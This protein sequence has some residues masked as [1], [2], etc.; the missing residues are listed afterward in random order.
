ML[1]LGSALTGFARAL[2]INP[3]LPRVRS[4]PAI[5][6][7]AQ[8]ALKPQPHT[9]PF[10]MPSEKYHNFDLVNRVKVK[11]G[12]V[13]ISKW[14]SRVSGLTLVHVD[15]QA[16]IV[17]GYFVVRSEIFNDSGCPHTLEHLVFMGSEKYP[18]KGVLDNLATRG[19]AEGT[20]AWTATDHTAYTISTAGGQGF[21]QLLPVYVDHIL[22]PTLTKSSFITEV[23]HVDVEGRDSGVVYSEMQGRENTPGDIAALRLQ[24]L[25]NPTGSAYRSETGGL[26]EALRV[27]T[28]NDIRKYH[29]EY[30]VPHNLSLIVSGKLNTQD[31]L[32][33]LQ[34]QVEPS[35]VK[36]GQTYGA[37][38]PPGFKRPFIETPSA[39]RPP[40]EK[41][42]TATTEF[43]EKDE[44]MGEVWMSFRGSKC[45]DFLTNGALDIMGNYLT[46]TAT[47]PLNKDLVEIPEPLCAGIWLSETDRATTN[48]IDFVASSVPTEELE[49]FDE[50]VLESLRKVVSEGIDM[51]K[52]QVIIERERRKLFAGLESKGGEIFADTLIADFLYFRENGEDLAEEVN[53]IEQFDELSRW[54]EQQWKDLLKTY[55]IDAHRVV[56]RAKPSSALQE[57]LESDESARV[58]AQVKKLGPEGLKKLGEELGAAKEE[59]DKPVPQEMLTEFP[60]PSVDSIGWI[61]VT[62]AQN[63]SRGRVVPAPGGDALATHIA[64]DGV[65]L[66]VFV[67]F[68]NIQSKFFSID[69]YISTA[70]L[71]DEL[72][73]LLSVY[74]ASFFSLPVTRSDG[75]KLSHEQ[76][77]DQLDNDTVLSDAS[78]GAGG[79][80]SQL[81]V[82]GFKVEASKYETAVMWLKDLLF[83][84]HFDVERLRIAVAKIQQ[85]LPETKRD[86][87]KVQ[88][89]I[90][91]S[92]INAPSS[93]SL[94]SHIETQLEFIPK[95]AQRLQDEPEAVVAE[96]ELI[97]KHLTSPEA[98]RF[99]AWG[100]IMSLPNPRAI[101]KTA[102][103]D[104][105]DTDLLPIPLRKESL[106]EL[107]RNPSKKAVVVT[108]PTIES[109]F[110]TFA[111]KS[112]NSWEHEDLA[113]LSVAI[114]VMNALESFLW[115]AIRGAGL[116]YGAHLTLDV[117]QGL[118]KFV[119]YRSPNSYLA[120][121]T[122]ADVTRKLVNGSTVI[123]Q[124]T[125]DSAKSSLVYTIAKSVSSPGKAA[126]A[127]F[128]N[129]VLKGAP[130]DRHLQMLHKY[131]DVTLEQV[132]SALKKYVLP[133]F[134][135]ASSI[136]AA[137]CS[138]AVAEKVAEGLK[139]AGYEVETRVWDAGED[140][141][142]DMHS[143]CDTCESG[144]SGSGSL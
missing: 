14:R 10:D 81:F 18:Y 120:Y 66:P 38:G 136:A 42:I 94:A 19:F 70:K 48:D 103:G 139:G 9:M 25:A 3:L 91:A 54:T 116:A 24:Q 72:R 90:L 104:V 118:L 130:Q 87:Q 74:V 100:D 82:P 99:V 71:P 135:P 144:S 17:N 96:L 88:G 127:S 62:S 16:P 36:H 49:T 26:M 92:M 34:E 89:S 5:R 85:S 143:D 37:R 33:V 45:G 55:F 39:N 40:F 134:E 60:V 57:K 123:E 27:L 84:S 69:A 129:Q 28:V 52:I 114:E 126:M 95:V 141:D 138:S 80:F 97:R 50:K 13:V 73:P 77:I 32:K 98:M 7:F 109:T 8:L 125:L 35:A 29:H 1:R 31:I 83:N 30:Y 56:V 20:N 117:E 64:K 78:I 111:T 59:N 75:T 63:K 108:M 53:D 65:E 47:S 142:V 58:E 43:P 21:L 23:H 12:D 137:T 15:Y 61:P 93:N 86:G 76:V 105:K 121:A 128:T 106:N 44:S 102:F 131:Q 133:V 46:S 122:G 22:Y 112:I 119:L 110:S 67:S 107:G 140:G 2:R 11:Y 68:H 41:T 124:T 132:R 4:P 51:K 113:A 101:W 79:S 6:P 115:K